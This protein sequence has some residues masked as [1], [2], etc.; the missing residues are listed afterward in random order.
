[1]TENQNKK[2]KGYAAIVSA[3]LITA[4]II[5]IVAGVSLA[6][7][8]GRA[9]SLNVTFKE[10]SRALANACVNVALLRLSEDKNYNGGE[11][12]AVGGKNCDIISVETV[13]LQTTITVKGEFQN[14]VTNVRRVVK[15][16][17]LT[18]V[19]WEEF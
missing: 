15:T 16:A 14:S 6:S 11:V 10:I 17:D 4:F 7:F 12:V 5:V 3:I 1:M 18:I 19:S 2:R 13:G 9:S 8:V